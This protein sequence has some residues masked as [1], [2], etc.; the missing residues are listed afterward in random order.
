[1]LVAGLRFQDDRAVIF[2]ACTHQFLTAKY[3]SGITMARSRI[4]IADDHRLVIEAFQKLL[5]SH[6]DVVGTA[7]D[8]LSL[9]QAAPPLKPHVVLID[10][11]MPLLNGLNAGRQ[12]KS[13][14]PAVKLVFVTMNE[15]PEIA[16]EAMREGASGYLLKSSAQE[17]LFQAIRL[18]LKG[19][20][21]VT[22]RIAKGMEEA[23]IRDPEAKRTGK[24]LTQRQREVIQ[25]L[26]EGKSMKQAADV[27]NVTAR[28]IAFH[29]YRVMET[30]GVKNT[31][32]L[33]QFAIYNH[34]V[35]G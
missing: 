14:M 12:L 25:L 27:L 30:L 5:E 8:G 23:F 18:A 19:G 33:I 28:T 3:L 24:T 9:L 15:D 16:R 10:L 34:I 17:E 22:P 20:S 26:A 6:Y 13:M 4:F 32:S 7:I 2:D 21:Y 11:A 29:K 31:A 35:I 1:M